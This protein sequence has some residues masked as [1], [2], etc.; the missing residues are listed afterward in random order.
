MKNKKLKEAIDYGDYPE[1]MGRNLE[2]TA[3]SPESLYGSN[4]AMKK[5][6][7]D[8]ERLLASR[9]KKVVDYARRITGINNLSSN[10]LQ[11]YL[12][13]EIS[14][15]AMIQLPEIEGNHIEEL[16]QLALDASIEET[17][18]DRNW[19]EFEISLNERNIDY[20]KFRTEPEDEDDEEEREQPMPSV[21]S[22]DVDDLTD[23]EELELEKHKR[24]IINA[25][26]QGA[27]KKGHYVFEKPEIKARLD[28]MDTR[29]YPMYRKIM[30]VI[31]LIYF[32]QDQ[33]I[34]SM[35]EQGW[36]VLGQNFL[37]TSSGDG[38]E[39]GEGED[40]PDTKIV[41]KAQTFPILCHEIIKGIKEASGRHGL[42]KDPVKAQKVMGQT[43]LL[44]NEPMQ[45]RIGPEL[46]E[47]LR[48]TLPDE[49]YSEENNG[50]I[51]WFE[52]V[53]Y[54][55]PARE[56]LNVI[57]NVVSDD[58]EKNRLAE[59]RFNEIMYEA[60]G[61]KNEYDSYKEQNN[62]PPDND[63]NLEDF[64]SGMGIKLPD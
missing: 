14:Q 51:G 1:R 32:T 33:F 38:D 62:I 6:P 53:L 25:I 27:A 43:D 13:N 63:D 30:A 8:V 46:Y 58:P 24:N 34:D 22:F 37:T 12:Y 21:P 50:L 16:K 11:Q 45:L 59:R 19:F 2:R 36:G 7:E 61:L 60:R 28:E 35:S 41:A 55:L 10:Q 64:L 4:P 57:G 17:E 5:G 48:L 31:D 15:M 18:I 9:F 54:Q 44:K 52:M 49:M 29:L 47:K 40:R 39:G 26:I 56:F 42:P 20:S 23:E 3:A